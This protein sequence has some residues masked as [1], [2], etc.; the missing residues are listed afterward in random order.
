MLF[1]NCQ[2][3]ADTAAGDVVPM[4][5]SMLGK[6]KDKTGKGDKKGK[7]KGKGKGKKSGNRR[8]KK[9]KD[10]G[11]ANAKETK[12]FPGYCLVSKAWRHATKDR[13]WNES[14]KS[15]KDTAS[16]ETPITPAENTETESS[17]TGMFIQSDEGDAVPANPAQWL[18]SVTKREP[19]REEFLIDPG[20]A[21]SVCQQSLADSLGGKPRGPGVELRSPTGHQFT[22]TRN[23]TICL[24]TRHGVNVAGDFQI[25]PKNTGLQRSIISVGQVCDRGNII[26]FRS[27]GGT[28]LNEFTGNRIEFERA[29]GVYESRHEGE[30]EV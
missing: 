15:G 19:S 28:T 12:H 5:L 21:T 13:W 4:D 7:G 22:A 9:S 18:Y 14:A 8:D 20:A 24:R 30:D 6:G 10:K 11:N 27:T 2:A 26:T 3:Q 17:V 1:D 23:T 25:A 16:L 29:G